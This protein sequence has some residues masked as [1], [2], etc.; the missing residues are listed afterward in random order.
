M[1]SLARA[2]EILYSVGMP[3]IYQA[4]PGLTDLFTRTGLRQT[5]TA[6]KAEI[7]VYTLA[8][9]SQ[10]RQRAS[11]A[12][13]HRIA[14]VYAEAMGIGQDAAL[15]LLFD[16]VADRKGPIRQ[17]DASGKFL[18]ADVAREADDAANQ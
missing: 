10:G 16:E 18:G 6:R 17:R 5:E 14:R 13:A 9:V 15:A 7:S 12:T 3:K 4:K 8:H 1:P 2:G 11:A